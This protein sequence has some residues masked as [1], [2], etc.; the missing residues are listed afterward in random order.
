MRP[1]LRR[2]VHIIPREALKVSERK[3]IPRPI[4]SQEEFKQ[5]TTI[6]L[7]FQQK[8]QAG[9]SWPSNIRLERAVRKREL[10]RVRPDL[11][12]ILKKMVNTE[13]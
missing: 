1:S 6:D 5:L 7:L 12:V 9:E 13:A 2:L 3:I 8:E 11:R 4:H 10:K